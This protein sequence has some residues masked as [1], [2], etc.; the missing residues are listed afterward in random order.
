MTYTLSSASFKNNT[1]NMPCRTT[2]A[3]M[4]FKGIGAKSNKTARR[5]FKKSKKPVFWLRKKRAFCFS[6]RNAGFSTPKAEKTQIDEYLYLN[7]HTYTAVK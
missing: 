3:A 7:M 4:K 5:I 1:G 6:Q 2:A